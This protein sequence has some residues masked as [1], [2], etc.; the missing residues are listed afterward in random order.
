M[1]EAETAVTVNEDA[2]VGTT[3]RTRTLIRKLEIS[4]RVLVPKPLFGIYRKTMFALLVEGR[5][6]VIK[7][8]SCYKS[9]RV[10]TFFSC[11]GL[12]GVI[13]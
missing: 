10:L 3:F 8:C 5:E 12:A 13:F 7:K 4:M 2:L 6:T 11:A 9:A 1:P